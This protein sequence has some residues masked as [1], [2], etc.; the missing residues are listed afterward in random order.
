MLKLLALA[1]FLLMIALAVYI[2]IMA[3]VKSG[4]YENLETTIVKIDPYLHDRIVQMKEDYRP[5]FARRIAGG[6]GLILLSVVALVTV[7]ILE[8]GGEFGSGCL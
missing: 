3:G 5:D 2:F 4:K 1:G 6:V 8:V 7:A